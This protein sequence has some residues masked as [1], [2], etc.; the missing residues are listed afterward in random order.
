MAITDEAEYRY[1]TVLTA[2]GLRE[3]AMLFVTNNTG[4]ATWEGDIPAEIYSAIPQPTGA[5]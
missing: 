1:C 2:R 3:R 5:V 4:K